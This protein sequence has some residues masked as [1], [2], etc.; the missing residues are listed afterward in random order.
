ME[1]DAIPHT[2]ESQ[3][4]SGGTLKVIQAEVLNFGGS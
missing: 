2:R 4:L 1:G 3:R